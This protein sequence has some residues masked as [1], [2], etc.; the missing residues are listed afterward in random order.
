MHIYDRHL[1]CLSFSRSFYNDYFRHIYTRNSYSRR[2]G[3]RL[4]GFRMLFPSEEH[5]T[6]EGKQE[7]LQKSNISFSPLAMPSLSGPGAIATVITISSSID[8][9][10]G[11]DKVF[12]FTGVVLAILITLSFHGRFFVAPVLCAEYLVSMELTVFQ[13]LWVFFLFV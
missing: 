13:E 6:Q 7:A 5:I 11:Y 3:N 2:N 12:S 8:G 10:H 9:R 4:S 1:N